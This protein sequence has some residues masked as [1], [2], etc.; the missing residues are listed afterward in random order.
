MRYDIM[1]ILKVVRQGPWASSR[2]FTS[3]LEFNVIFRDGITLWH[4]LTAGSK[5]RDPVPAKFKHVTKIVTC[6]LLCC[7]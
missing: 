4:E 3:P 7:D 2:Y 6:T 1:S 5:I